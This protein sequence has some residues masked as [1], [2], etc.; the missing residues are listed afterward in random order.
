M[1]WARF[2][3]IFILAIFGTRF[4]VGQSGFINFAII[5]IDK[6]ICINCKGRVAVVMIVIKIEE[7]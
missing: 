1:L 3:H 2:Y 5:E 4:G 7:S 6:L